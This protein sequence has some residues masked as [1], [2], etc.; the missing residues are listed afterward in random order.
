MAGDTLAYKEPCFFVN[1]YGIDSLERYLSL[2]S[3]VKQQKIIGDASTAYLAAPES[4]EKIHRFN[5]DAKILICLRNPADRAYS[6]YCWMLQE[7]YERLYPFEHALACEASRQIETTPQV[8]DC[9][10]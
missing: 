6:L 8:F 7:G 1:G 3:P 2:F 10:F 5:P 4:A 9:G